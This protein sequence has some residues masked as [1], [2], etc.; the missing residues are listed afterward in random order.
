M[1]P[2]LVARL[3]AARPR[4]ACTSQ[5]AGIS[6][7]S[8]A[9]FSALIGFVASLKR[10]PE[11]ACRVRVVAQLVAEP[12]TPCRFYRSLPLVARRRR[13]RSVDSSHLTPVYEVNCEEP[14]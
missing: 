12:P 13:R 11:R 3:V 9:L 10:P 8:A 4:A 7:T 2:K 6:L 5:M 1:S 14:G